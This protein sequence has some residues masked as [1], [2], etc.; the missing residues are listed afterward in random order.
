MAHPHVNAILAVSA[1]VVLLAAGFIPAPPPPPPSAP[2]TDECGRFV[3]DWG[4]RHFYSYEWRIGGPNAQYAAMG[5][6][7]FSNPDD[8][9]RRVR[10]SQQNRTQA[11]V[12][13]GALATEPT[14]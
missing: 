14:R 12:E 7:K 3:Q 5:S 10:D 11:M 8:V 6:E 4:G 9:G 13:A 2:S 1:A